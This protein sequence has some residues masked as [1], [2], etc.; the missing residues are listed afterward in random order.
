VSKPT[1]KNLPYL[2]F[3]TGDSNTYKVWAEEY[4]EKE[5]NISAIQ[6]IFSHQPL[7]AE[8][9]TKLNTEIN[10]QDLAEDLDEIGYPVK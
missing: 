5:F 4:Y 10:I 2:N 1:A 8:M 6:D 3:L 7:T 9:I